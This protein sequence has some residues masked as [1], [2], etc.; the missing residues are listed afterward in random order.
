MKTTGGR[1]SLVPLRYCMG[2]RIAVDPGNR[3]A[4]GHND[5]RR[6][7]AA[8]AYKNLYVTMFHWKRADVACPWLAI[9]GSSDPRKA[10]F[11][12]NGPTNQAK[13]DQDLTLSF[14]HCFSLIQA[15]EGLL[16]AQSLQ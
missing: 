15:Q 8:L 5:R 4:G 3:R 6:V 2:H 1:G 13:H 11:E 12:Q 16:R 10:H 9:Q 7:I 14:L